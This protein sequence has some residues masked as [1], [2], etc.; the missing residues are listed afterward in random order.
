MARVERP[1]VNPQFP[2]RRT[3]VVV[4]AFIGGDDRL[5]SVAERWTPLTR[6]QTE[7]LPLFGNS[8]RVSAVKPGQLLVAHVLFHLSLQ[9][10]VEVEADMRKRR[11]K[12]KPASRKPFVQSTQRTRLFNYGNELDDVD[13]S[14]RSAVTSIQFAATRPNPLPRQSH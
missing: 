6:W 7:P 3:A 9:K 5:I 13:T 10:L 14:Q 1:T 12:L 2:R 8:L 11:D 4:V